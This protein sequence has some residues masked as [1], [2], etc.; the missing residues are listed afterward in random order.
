MATPLSSRIQ[1]LTGT[2]GG[3]PAARAVL[4]EPIRRERRRGG[5]LAD[6]ACAVPTAAEEVPWLRRLGFHRS[7]RFQSL[8]AWLAASPVSV[9]QLASSGWSSWVASSSPRPSV[10]S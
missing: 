8:R 6:P 4:H 10:V 1:C 3:G 5:D 9:R 7:R 2:G